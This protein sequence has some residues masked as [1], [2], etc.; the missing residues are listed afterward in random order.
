MDSNDKEGE[1]AAG[2]SGPDP[3]LE[4][5]GSFVSK[6]LKLKPEKW[7]RCVTVEENRIII[8][9]FL[10]NTTPTTLVVMLTQAAQLVVAA[11]FPLNNL[12]SK[13]IYFIKRHPQPVPRQDCKHFLI[14]GDL[15]TRTIDQLSVLV[16]E[17]FVPLLA[18]KENYKAWPTMVGQDVQK[19]IHSLKSTVHQV[20][21]Q[22]SGETILAMPVG[23]DEMVK[24]SAQISE[25]P[26]M[27]IDLYLKS[28]IEGV[29]I[30]WATQIN[31]VVKET[32][33][34]AFLNGQNPVPSAG[35]CSRNCPKNIKCI[36]RFNNGCFC[37]NSYRVCLLE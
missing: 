32:P 34:D 36:Q 17:I 37:S 31:D 5:M 16:E 23:V 24:I 9:D 10:D 3:R 1:E 6:S 15:A 8:K 20:R 33:S 26:S 30:K 18:F 11:T 21:G 12:K 35:R 22:V 28:A 19:Q 2:G 29:V 14:Y 7:T 13:G 4:L 27:S 25:N